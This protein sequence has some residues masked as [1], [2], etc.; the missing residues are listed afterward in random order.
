MEHLFAPGSAGERGSLGKHKVEGQAWNVPKG[1]LC[2]GCAGIWEPSA[3]NEHRTE[4]P[5]DTFKVCVLLLCAHVADDRA[6]ALHWPSDT[7][8]LVNSIGDFIKI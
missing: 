2:G 3:Q 6:W 5:Q 1:G 4:A 8:R 7:H